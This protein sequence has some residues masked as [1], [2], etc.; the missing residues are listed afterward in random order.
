M[1]QSIKAK[2]SGMMRDRVTGT[3]KI[4]KKTARIEI[5]NYDCPKL[6]II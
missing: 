4:K 1:L 5:K 2:Q 6:E 3:L